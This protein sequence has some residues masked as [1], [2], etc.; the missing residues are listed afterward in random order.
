MIGMWKRYGA[1]GI[2]PPAT[3]EPP[4]VSAETRARFGS[5]SER[6]SSSRIMNSTH[7]SRSE[8]TASVAAVEDVALEAPALEDLAD[9]FLL[10]GRDLVDLL[11]LAP[12]LGAPRVGLALGGE[13]AAEAHRDRA[14]RELGDARDEDDARARDGAREA[15]P[16]ARTGP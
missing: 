3:Y 14:G 2:A 8:Q 16:R 15:R 13:V 9:L 6:C 12:E 1:S 5:G 11:V 7:R 4:I 10:L